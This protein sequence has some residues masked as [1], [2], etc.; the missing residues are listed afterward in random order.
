MGTAELPELSKLDLKNSS[1]QQ[2]LFRPAI[3]LSLQPRSPFCH[4][5]R[6][7]ISCF[8][9]LA[10]TRHVVLLKENHTL[11]IGAA[12][13]DRKSGEGEGSAVLRA[14]PGTR[15]ERREVGV[16]MWIR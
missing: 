8:T 10:T 14:F 7:Q 15:I 6:T 2:P 5:E 11:L 4:P 12:A 16:S 3:A 1:V 9:I 13:L